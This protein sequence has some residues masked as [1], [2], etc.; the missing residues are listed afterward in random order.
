MVSN[1]NSMFVSDRYRRT[2]FMGCYRNIDNRTCIL[3]KLSDHRISDQNYQTTKTIGFIPNIIRTPTFPVQKLMYCTTIHFR[4]LFYNWKLSH[5]VFTTNM[6]AEKTDKH[7][8]FLYITCLSREN[9][10]RVQIQKENLLFQPVKTSSCQKR[11]GSLYDWYLERDLYTGLKLTFSRSWHNG[12][13]LRIWTQP[14]LPPSLQSSIQYLCTLCEIVAF[15]CDHSSSAVCRQSVRYASAQP[16]AGKKC[17]V[18]VLISLGWRDGTAGHSISLS[19]NFSIQYFLVL[20]RTGP[21][22]VVH[23]PS[24]PVFCQGR[25]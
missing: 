18:A 3:G 10:F 20:G 11:Y 8:I 13:P 24:K 1:N 5:S 21:G 4:Y 22:F 16:P 15:T 12:V 17:D 19:S 2:T 14:S 6:Q 7:L 23:P 25:P 9:V